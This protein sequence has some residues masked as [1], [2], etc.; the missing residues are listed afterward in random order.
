MSTLTKN[1]NFFQP[2]L[3]DPADITELNANWDRID[4]E[5]AS[6]GNRIVAATSTDGVSYE[7]TVPY[8]D[9]L[10]NGLE[11]TII[12]NMTSTVVNPT[13]NIN[14]LGAKYIKVPLSTNTSATTD[15]ASVGFYTK[16]KP[17]KLMFN[18]EQAPDGVWQTVDKQRTSAQDLYGAVPVANGGTGADNPKE[19]RQNLGAV[20]VETTTITLQTSGWSN[21]TQTVNVEGVTTDNLVIVTHSPNSYS[22]YVDHRVRLHAQASGSLTFK[23]DYTPSMAITVNIAIFD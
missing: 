14:S 15:P 11:I 8:L 3:H 19:A 21:L 17:V 2:E 5:L 20:A 1:F 13:L 4:T 9:E 6:A 23:C 16:G 12:P 10:H 22:D 18:T 7:A